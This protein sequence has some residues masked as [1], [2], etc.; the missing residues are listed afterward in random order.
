MLGRLRLPE[1]TVHQLR[2]FPDPPKKTG[3][4]IVVPPSTAIYVLEVIQGT[5]HT[6]H[7]FDEAQ[8]EQATK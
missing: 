4:R 1:K 8:K 7:K 2:Q 5:Q 3:K 6:V